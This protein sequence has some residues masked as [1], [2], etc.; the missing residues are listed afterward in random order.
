MK[1]FVHLH[2]HSHYSLLDGLAKIDE[3]VNRAKELGMGALA[4]TDHGNLY[5]AIEF[6]KTAKA[7]GIKPILGV[8]AYIAGT[9]PQ[10]KY[11]HLILLAK[12]AAGWKNIIKL[13][14]HGYLKGFY[15]KPQ[16]D[17]E[18]LRQYADGIV[19]LSACLSGEVARALLNN[20]YEKAKK[21]ALEY[22][23]M[24]GQGNFF[25]EIGY[26]PGLKET[27][28]IHDSLIKLS[29]ETGIQLAATQDIHYL[30]KEDADVHDIF[31]AIQT[32]DKVS[33]SDRLS[34]KDDDFSMTSPEQMA[35]WFS[36]VPEAVTNTMKVAELCNLELELG[37]VKLPRFATPNGQSAMDYLKEL[38]SQRLSRRYPIT[39]P[40]I[41][42]RLDYEIGV[43]EKTGFAAYFLIVQDFINWAKDHGIVVGPG[44]GSAAGSLVAYVLNITDVDP[45][46]YD[47]LFERFLNPER[48]QMP[49]IDIDFTD[50]RRDE[51]F[52]YLKEKYGEDH[53]ANI[54]T[55][56]TMAARL[57]V[58]D[59]GRALGIPL[60]LCDQVA[61]L[62]P[63]NKSIDEAL[64]LVPE[65]A[66][67]YK[68]NPD[69]KKIVDPARRL[70]GVVRHAST[71]ACGTVISA[72]PLTETIPL[73]KSKDVIV[74]QFEMHTIEDLGLLK[75]DLLGLKNLTIIEDAV[76]LVTERIGK[77]IDISNLPEN[78]AATYKLLQAADTTGVFQLES[79]GMRRYLKELNPTELEDIT[80][81]VAVYRPGPMELI[82]QYISRKHK[83]EP[84]IYLHP[85]VEPVFK[86]TYGIM[87]Y[88]EQLMAAARALAGLSLAEADVLRKAVGKKIRKLLLEQREKLIGGCIKN[89]VSKQIAEQFWALIEPFDRYGFN[90]SHAVCYATIAYQ[91]AYLKA[92]Y[93]IEFMTALLNADSGDIDRVA[94]VI[95][96]CKRMNINVLPP[97]INKSSALFTPEE[98]NIRFGLTAIKNLGVAIVEALIAERAAGGPFAGLPDIL[99]RIRHKD[100]NKKS[101]DALVKS[102]ALDSLGHERNQIVQNLDDILRFASIVKKERQ[103]DTENIIQILDNLI[104]LMAE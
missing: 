15:Y 89:G 70:E 95:S 40:A 66:E 27:V 3:L 73:Q 29:R 93:P 17:K 55:F 51:V 45:L 21:I 56:G 67:L 57:S 104:P 52:G 2:T 82:P 62:I 69:V 20:D 79:S 102:G 8:E 53:V 58:R 28:K 48:I 75:M 9:D 61:K 31:L 99:N 26:H 54:I 91:T 85:K 25:I 38:V 7:A 87:I 30:K 12:N 32:G 19:A 96:E 33:D 36:D 74:T 1:N 80:A 71:H 42:E 84:V 98:N 90:R 64:A 13:V 35:E 76:R 77:K 22:Q 65:F 49:D 6:Y 97:D 83:R 68:K 88:Q 100:L 81:I 60:S 10:K 11:F 16:I 59:V 14:T 5:G 43:I 4:L 101:L 94:F 92:H 23:E 103:S 37:K 24:F 63:F 18:T 46:K 78:D 86:N 72:E 34:L 50:R 44:R 39:T 47:L 41:Q